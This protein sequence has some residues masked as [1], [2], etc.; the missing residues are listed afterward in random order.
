MHF[1][2]VFQEI[3]SLRGIIQNRFKLRFWKRGYSALFKETKQRLGLLTTAKKKLVSFRG[4]HNI[5]LSTTANNRIT[6]AVVEAKIPTKSYCF[7][8][9]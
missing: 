3:F 6:L 8:P 9:Y 4:N 5:D 2:A 7:T 1:G